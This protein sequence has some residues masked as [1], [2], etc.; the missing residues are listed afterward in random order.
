[1]RE[2]GKA[3]WQEIALPPSKSF[4]HRAMLI[5]ALSEPGTTL[6][7][8]LWAEDTEITADGLEQLGVRWNRTKR[9]LE[10]VSLTSPAAAVRVWVGN[11]GTSARFLA[12][13]A[14]LHSTAPVTFDG[15]PRMRQRPMKALLRALEQLG[16]RVVAHHGQL[17]FVIIGGKL[18]PATVT[19]PG[20][21]SSQ[22]LSALL[23]IAARIGGTT[24]VRLMTPLVSSGYVAMTRWFLQCLGV[25]VQWQGEECVEIRGQTAP[26][27][28]RRWQVE[29]DWSAAAFWIVGALVAQQPVRLPALARK[30][31]QHDAAIVPLLQEAG[32]A[33]GWEGDA[34]WVRGQCRAG[35][36]TSLRHIPD[37]FPALAVYATCAET[38]SRFWDYEHLRWKESDRIAVVVGNL[39]RLGVPIREGERWLE[40]SPV[41]ELNPVRIETAGDHRIAM[42]FALL[43]F[44]QPALHL[45]D[46]Q[47][48]R[49]SY[50]DYWKHWQQMWEML[51]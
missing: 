51:A 41:Q 36:E 37:L 25:D 48:V 50:P 38:P 10:M 23:L 19:I 30:T 31:T 40:I 29:R 27:P 11:S 34:L 6:E 9:R 47:C 8:P 16:A 4:T 15:T 13:F 45:D 3:P 18:R 28:A 39:R 49:K 7:D 14:A 1:M 24:T 5:A 12:A 42:A 22:F 33:I 20:H 46:T 17:P 43:K 2:R 26:L 32:N 21:I 35:I 44:R